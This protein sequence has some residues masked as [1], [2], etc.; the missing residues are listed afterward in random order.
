MRDYRVQLNENGQGVLEVNGNFIRLSEVSAPSERYRITATD[1]NGNEV[2][3]INMLEG[4]FIKNLPR[5]YNRIR[6]SNENLGLG[7]VVLIAGNGEYEEGGS[8]DSGIEQN[9]LLPAVT[10][11]AIADGDTFTIPANDSRKRLLIQ[12]GEFN[13][14]IVTLMGGFEMTEAM[15][16]DRPIKSAVSVVIEKADDY[17]V[18]LEEV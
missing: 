18:Y 16:F 13:A 2:T 7:T 11:T 14:G 6:V 1:S 9:E 5:Q 15:D 3:S 8:S 12:T 17:L 4:G 10:M